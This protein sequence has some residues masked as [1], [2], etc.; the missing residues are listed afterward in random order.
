[1]KISLAQYI[2]RIGR[3][4]VVLMPL[5]ICACS[6]SPDYARPDT[7]LPT[8]YA[9][10]EQKPIAENGE[11]WLGFDS[12]VLPRLQAMALKSNYNFA[13]TRWNLAQTM[14]Q[15]R[16]TRAKLLPE[17]GA[18]GSGSRR[19]SEASS[20]Y[21]VTDA[22][23]GTMQ[24]S[25]ELDI[26]GANRESYSAARMQVIAGLNGWRGVGLSLESE[27]ALTYFSYLAAKE[28][29]EVYESMLGNARQVLDYQEKRERL[30]AAAPLDVARQRGSV[31]SMEA[32]RLSY[33]MKMDEARNSLCGLLGI[34]SLPEE[35][36]ALIAQ[37]RLMTILPPE[38]EAGIPS[39]LL[40]RRPDIAQAEAQLVSANANIGVAR[41][42]FLPS[43]SLSASAGYQSDALSS[44]I[45]PGNAFYSLA[46]ALA[47]P[48]FNFGKL[49]AKHES[50]LAAKEE[51]VLR[52]QESALNAFLEVS[53]ALTANSLLAEQQTH[54]QSSAYET[55]EAYRVAR[56]R[57]TSGAEDFLSVLDAQDSMLSARNSLV[58]NRLE[59]LN[60]A[61]TLFKALGGG[62]G[63][64]D[65]PI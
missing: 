45:I 17:V 28:N 55:A 24:A 39:D 14:A 54:R 1:M 34:A 29:F 44:L 59:R 9:A 11:W 60:S 12:K 7:D 47:L 31:A 35:L 42:A 40:A 16:V 63:D 20:G 6:L 53:T 58:Q 36:T 5:L 22:F 62:W 25:Y 57:Y 2:K 46:T 51:M 43:I 21:Q 49:R 33:L 37:E 19:G 64:K 30:G 38:V 61:V 18:S 15:A 3:G 26:W 41:S 52:Y 13:A 48:I 50:A 32:E 23:S 4:L 56:A 65:S 10:E 8:E 27:V